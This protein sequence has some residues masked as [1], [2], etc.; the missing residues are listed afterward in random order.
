MRGW[1]HEQMRESALCYDVPV[2][3]SPDKRGSH[4]DRYDSPAAPEFGCRLTP[5]KPVMT[6]SS[7]LRLLISSRYPSAWSSG[8]SGCIHINSGRLRGN[9]SAAAFNFMM[10]EP[11]EIME[12]AM[13]DILTVK[14]LDI[15][16]H[17]RF[18]MIFIEHF[19]C[20]ISALAFQRLINSIAYGNI[21]HFGVV[22]SCRQWQR[23]KATHW[24]RIRQLFRQYSYLRLHYQSSAD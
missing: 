20:Q 5:A 24:Q 12:W 11:R 14:A 21:I 8:T 4:G 6:L 18:R 2:R 23:W 13:G 1:Y 17:L 10:Q 9:I 16:H 7:S 15:A 3:C 19:M 22:F